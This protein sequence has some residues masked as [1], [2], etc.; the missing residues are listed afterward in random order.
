MGIACDQEMNNGRARQG[1]EIIILG[2]GRETRS[3]FRIGNHRSQFSK[4]TYVFQ[5]FVLCEV[6]AELG[7]EQN[8]FQLPKQC[9]GHY[10]LELATLPKL[11]EF[12][13]RSRWREH[14][15]DK[16]TGVQYRPERKSSHLT[17]VGE[18]L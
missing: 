3:D 1:D 4:I 15:G 5:C 17:K 9:L 11:H 10:H 14:G 2:V 16:H 6:T 13:G 12:R 7:A 8:A 18:S